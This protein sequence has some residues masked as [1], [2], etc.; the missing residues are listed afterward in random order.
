[1]E[2]TNF[3][4][5]MIGF[6]QWNTGVVPSNVRRVPSQNYKRGLLFLKILFSSTSGID[7]KIQNLVLDIVSFMM[8]HVILQ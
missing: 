7:V 5:I 1:M 4:K 6:K 3:V 2:K 8:K